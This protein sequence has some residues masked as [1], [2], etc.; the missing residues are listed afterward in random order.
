MKMKMKR[1]ITTLLV[2][3]FVATMLPPVS[4]YAATETIEVTVNVDG[5]EITTEALQEAGTVLVPFSFLEEAIGAIASFNPR[6]RRISIDTAA[7]AF[8]MEV[9]RRGYTRNGAAR[10]LPVAPRLVEGVPFVPMEPIITGIGGV[11]GVDLLTST[12][13]ITYFSAITGRVAIGGSTTLHPF[14][15]EA[16]DFLSELN[17]G[18]TV[19]VAAGGSGAGETGVVNRTIN[20]G[21]ISRS[22]GSAFQGRIRRVIPV[23]HDAVAIVVHPSNPITDLSMEDARAIFMGE[24]TNWNEV[25]GNN[26]PIIIHTRAP[27][28][29]TG[30]TV[31]D[32][33]L[34]SGNTVVATATPHVSNGLQRGAVAADANSIGFLS[35]GYLDATVSGVTLGGIAPTFETVTSGAYPLGRN[36]YLLSENRPAGASARVIDFIRTTH[37]QQEFIVGAEFLGIRPLN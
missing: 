7:F 23:A 8:R 32:M 16:A 14:M 31:N 4:V 2:M 10:Q 33:L 20:I 34:G 25:G 18:L 9:G 12:L 11:I 15:Q 35:V 22:L 37:A 36:L 5:F 26:A 3:A 1:I 17:T 27:G 30:D 19:T 13:T 28:S 21:M 24:I 6:T 29:G